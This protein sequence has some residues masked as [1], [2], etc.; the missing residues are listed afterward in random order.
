MQP[1]GG[2]GPRGA[3]QG[4]GADRRCPKRAEEPA[5]GSNTAGASGDGPSGAGG[6]RQ[7]RSVSEGRSEA[8][9]GHGVQRPRRGESAHPRA[10]REDAEGSG[11]WPWRGW[12]YVAD[13][14][15]VSPRDRV[16][17]FFL[18]VSSLALFKSGRR[19]RQA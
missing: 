9:R 1:R 5:R 11:V 10:L 13:Q 12:W 7:L 17:G 19:V 6:C 3:S 4:D 14:C 16:R 18:L 2:N 8:G 15:V